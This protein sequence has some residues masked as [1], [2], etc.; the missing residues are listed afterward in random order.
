MT[1]L[2]MNATSIRIFRVLS[3]P[4]AL[5]VLCVPQ[6]FA[7]RETQQEPAVVEGRL[8]DSQDHAVAGAAVSLAC[9]GMD[10]PLTVLSDSQGRFR[11]E[12]VPAATCTLHAK[13]DSG[14]EAKEGPF[15]LH[16]RETKSVVLQVKPLPKDASAAIEFS[17]EPQFT[18][19]G[20]TDT[21][22]LG[23]HGSDRVVRNSEAMSK[24]AA[25]LAR[26]PAAQPGVAL[27]PPANAMAPA[28]AT[29][30]ELRASLAKQETADAHFQLAEIEESHGRPLEAAK[31]YQRAS[32]LDPSEPHLFAWG[33]ELLLHRASEP[34]AEVFAKGRRLYPRSVRMRL[35][36]G[37]AMYAQD[38]R[39]EAAKIFLE[40]SDLDPSDALPYLF[41]G[42]LQVTETNLPAG[43]TN[44]MKR[45]V[46]LHPENA[47]AHCLYAAALAKL[48]REE[49]NSEAIESQLRTAIT[50]D[51]KL[52]SAYLQLGIL[53][54]QRRDY[55]GAAAAFQKAVEIIPLPDEA[56]Y[57]LADVYRR[58]GQTDQANKETELFKQISAQKKQQVE[59]ERHEIQQF[60]YTLRGGGSSTPAPPNSH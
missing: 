48:G 60:V 35:G 17:D 23:G 8:H 59:R 10:K 20:V 6:L 16:A 40:A 27:H 37:A 4:S 32:E 52:G 25:S 13:S 12:A 46:D 44:R 18:V 14:I 55:P 5:A 38:L 47:T 2:P 24:D 50:L 53:L 22:A 54:A 41:L 9:A 58:M 19:A 15:T 49:Q 28:A 43:W 34:A 3:A 39:A 36:L 31:D 11:F 57:R 26:E 51:P 45:F 29:E 30:A 42:R 56:H 33:A 1:G 7:Q 21:T